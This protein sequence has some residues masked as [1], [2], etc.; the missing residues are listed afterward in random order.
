MPVIPFFYG[1]TV[2]MYYFDN[3]RHNLPHIH[4]QHGDD[5][6]VIGIPDGDVIEGSLRRTQLRLVQAWVEIHKDEL[7]KN[8]E[9][10]INGESVS[11]IAPLR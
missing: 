6:T 3:K 10:A 7:M 4:V 9:L 2:L 11:K 1:V 5:E 8:W